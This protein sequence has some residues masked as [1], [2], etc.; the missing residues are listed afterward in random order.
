MSNS[1]NFLLSINAFVD[2][3]KAKNELVVKKASIKI[4]QDIIRM[5]PVGQPELWLGYAPKGYVGGR[6][7]GN[8]QVTFN[9]P[10]SVELDR[11]DPSGMDTLKDGIEQIGRYTYGI[12]SIYFTNNLPY[13][14]RLEFGHSKQAP[15]GIV[16]IAALNA[17]A[18]FD[19]A[20]KG[21]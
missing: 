15:N 18:H 21:G 10:A 13:S 14:V 9:V 3:A 1:Q 4:L 16:R 6:F 11:V 12:Q 8:W 20:A 5:S 2:K 7:R 17:Q 19:N